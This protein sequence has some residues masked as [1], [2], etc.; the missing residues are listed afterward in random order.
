M[1]KTY[2]KSDSTAIVLL[3]ILSVIILFISKVV[4]YESCFLF[5]SNDDSNHTFVNLF[6]SFRH[7]K[8]LQL[9]F[10]NIFNNF[11]TPLLGD[12]LT[13]P[14][15]IASLTYLLFDPQLAMTIN[16]IASATLILLLSFK[17]FSKYF[18]NIASFILSLVLLFTPGI[19]WN[20]A[21]HHYQ[22]AIPFFFLI[23]HFISSN[24]KSN[25]YNSILLFLIFIFYLLSV[26][27][28]L[29][30][31]SLPFIFLYNFIENRKKLKSTTF[32]FISA[33]I[34]TLP[35]HILFFEY[36]SQSVRLGFT[37]YVGIITSIRDLILS[38]FVPL[39]EWSTFGVNGHFT[40]NTYMSS[41]FIV[42]STIG[43]Y[44]AL[45]YK[46]KYLNLFLF[47]GLIPFL[48]AY[49]IQFRLYDLS[50]FKSID[51][52]R[53]I[54]FASPF[55]MF[56]LGYFLDN[57]D[58]LHKNQNIRWLSFF[59]GLTML[60]VY[61]LPHGID[62]FNG[63]GSIHLLVFFLLVLFLLR[64]SYRSNSFYFLIIL[65]PK[66]I[67]L[68]ALIPI[69]YS[70]LGFSYKSCSAPNHYF[71]KQEKLKIFPEN[72]AVD[73]KPF[74]RA[75]FIEQP[76]VGNDLKLVYSNILGSASRSIISSKKLQTILKEQNM[77]QLSDNYFFK[78]PWNFEALNR[79]NIRYII[80]PKE[81]Y[82]LNHE[83]NFLKNEDKYYIYENP[84]KPTIA[85]YE[86]DKSKSFINKINLIPNGIQ[87][88]VKGID[89]SNHKIRISLFNHKHWNVYFDG[90]KNK[91]YSD[92][93]GMMIIDPNDETFDI[94]TIKYGDSLIKYFLI[95][96]IFGLLFF[97]KTRRFYEKKL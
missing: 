76:G 44:S 95:S 37:P 45:K 82:K 49:F 3:L 13:Y 66:F 6:E 64:F 87:L 77:I 17:F 96:I 70:I 21:H 71:N 27:I 41:A 97:A 29:V 81:D 72:I 38:L 78:P 51:S 73:L 57:L 5:D 15:S 74:S 61:F 90:K 8:S 69:I 80:S 86:N 24:N 50:I 12:A 26:S 94:L 75:T 67:L 89:L 14:F 85:S 84:V 46:Y 79:L 1:Y 35:H 39:S 18:S 32:I 83:W 2:Q 20:L 36:I 68:L 48:C 52:L 28:Q 54:W 63:V 10:I 59:F 7:L 93:L 53:L 9:P 25:N 22:L 65:I 56:P 62:E 43:L 30:V 92:D 55:L 47:L 23:I 31:F 91:I 11:G 34:L 88:N 33:L 4:L 60:I 19:L 16:R 42:L 40:I 58:K